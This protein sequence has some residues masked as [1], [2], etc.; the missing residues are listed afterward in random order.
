MA[1]RLS[2]HVLENLLVF[3]NPQ[4]LA[5]FGQ[6]RVVGQRALQAQIKKIAEGH[7]VTRL[8]HDALV[9]EIILILQEFELQQQE[10][11]GGWPTKFGTVARNHIGAEAFKI[12]GGAHLTQIVIFSNSGVED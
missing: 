4:P 5:K 12:D 6:Q 8:L 3:F 9:S 2:D 1:T 11:F 10:R 7:I